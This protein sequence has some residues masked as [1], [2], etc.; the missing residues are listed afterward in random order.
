MKNCT[1]IPVWDKTHEE[2]Q[3]LR[4]SMRGIGGSDAGTVCGVNAYNSAYALWAEKTGRVENTFEGNEATKWG[5]RL[6]RIVAEAYAEDYNR[7]IVAWPVILVSED[8]PFMFANVDFLEV[9]ASDEFP[10][11]QIT[12][13]RF[14]DAPPNIVSI[15]EVKTSGIATHGNA[16]HWANDQIPQSYMLQGYHYGIV[17]GIENVTFAALIGGQG[18]LARQME[19]DAEIAENIVIAESMFWDLVESDT[20]PEVDGSDATEA[21]QQQRYPRH[22]EGKE[23]EGDAAFRELWQEFRAA[24]VAAEEADTHRK[25]LRAKVIETIGDAEFASVDGAPVLSYKANKDTET[26]DADRLK[27]EAPEIFNQFKKVR[28]GARTLRDLSK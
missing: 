12:T 3:E 5:Q 7:A 24:K 15:L 16:G 4:R 13:W 26:L 20:A 8:N 9:E 28:A 2:W 11:G 10:A 14:R 25:S 21:V 17:T 23:Y 18:L 6:E 1:V 22:A 27:R 19:W